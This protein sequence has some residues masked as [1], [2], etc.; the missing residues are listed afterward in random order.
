MTD[1]KAVYPNNLNLTEAESAK[2]CPYD[3]Y[4]RR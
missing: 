3:E 1:R 4:E 2:F